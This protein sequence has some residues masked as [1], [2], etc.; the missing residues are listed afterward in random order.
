MRLMFLGPPGAG[1]GT[2][3][4]RIAV[5]MG[6]AH[7]STGD[8][9]R[10]EVKN[11]TPLGKKAREYIDAGEYVPDAVIISMV[12]ERISKPDAEKGFILDGFPRTQA[13]AEA[14]EGF[15]SLDAVINVN[16]SDDKLMHRICGRRVC[17]ACSSTYH[18][19][20]LENLNICPK[21]K[22]TLYVRDDDKEETVKVRISVYKEKTQPLIDYYIKK[23]ILHDIDGSGGIDDIT[24]RIIAALKKEK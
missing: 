24:D 18:E 1:K 7:I 22:G 6:I 9:L 19:S 16:V 2:Q 10:E 15:T 11:S 12:K 13:Q 4:A 3:A 21:C 23:G 8:M 14:L 20:M 5:K 17:R